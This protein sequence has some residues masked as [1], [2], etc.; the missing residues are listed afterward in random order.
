[1]KKRIGRKVYDTENAIFVHKYVYGYF[2][3]PTGYEEVLF[4]TEDGYYFLYTR[5]GEESPYPKEDIKRLSKENAQQWI[6]QH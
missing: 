3:V 1:M 5:G 4:Q 6:A 2:G